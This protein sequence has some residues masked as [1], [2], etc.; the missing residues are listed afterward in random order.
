MVR[1]PACGWRM[2]RG[3]LPGGSFACPGCNTKL[4]WP[5]GFG[6]V[7]LTS[8]VL[9]ALL[10]FLGPYMMGIHGR[11][12]LLYAFLLY[13]PIVSAISLLRALLFPQRLVRDLT[14]G[15]D[16]IQNIGG[17]PQRPSR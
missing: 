5:K 8:H 3:D 14:P 17:G 10:A 4:R 1:C 9:T 11:K 13:A 2:K 16:G 7:L 12:L 6:L 15:G